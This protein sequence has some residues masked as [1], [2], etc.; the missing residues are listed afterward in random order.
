MKAA[1]YMDNFLNGACDANSAI[2]AIKGLGDVGKGLFSPIEAGARY[3][4]GGE[5]VTL[6]E[7]LGKTFLKDTSTVFRNAEG[8]LVKDA[9][10]KLVHNEAEA[11]KLLG[12]A[13]DAE[14]SQGMN[15][16]LENAQ[17]SKA[18]L[19]MSG[20][21]VGMGVIGGLTHDSAGNTDIA[22]IPGI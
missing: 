11:R 3:F 14:I 19:G 16:S 9:A 8:E 18:L 1:K 17:K 13:A 21:G 22:G 7:S 4:R 10:G 15:W 2:N 12:L 6:S 20:I 5:G